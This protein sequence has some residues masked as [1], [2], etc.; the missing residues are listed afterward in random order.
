MWPSAPKPP[1]LAVCTNYPWATLVLVPTWTGIS[2]PGSGGA[3][4]AQWLAASSVIG[5]AVLSRKAVVAQ[6][7][8]P[9]PAQMVTKGLCKCFMLAAAPTL[10]RGLPE[11]AR[12]CQSTVS[13]AVPS[14]VR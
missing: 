7:A 1:P 2:K 11:P 10:L 9:F 8:S 4:N 13:V 6:P 12:T 3:I 5:L 14:S